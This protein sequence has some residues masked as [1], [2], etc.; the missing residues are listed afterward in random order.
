MLIMVPTVQPISGPNRDEED[1]RLQGGRPKT[2]EHFHQ[3]VRSYQG[4]VLV[5]VAW[6]E[7]QLLE[8]FLKDLDPFSPLGHEQART[9]GHGRPKKLSVRNVLNRHYHFARGHAYRF[10]LTL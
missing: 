9:R 4:V 7:Y 6:G 5:F 8:D 10:Q 3:P 1:F 2:A